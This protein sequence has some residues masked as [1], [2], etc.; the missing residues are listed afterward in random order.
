M[1]GAWLVSYIALWLLTAVLAIVV[2]AHS[3]LLGLLHYRLGP[4]GARPLAD[5]PELGSTVTR[6]QGRTL[7]GA[8]WSYTFP[9]PREVL[10]IFVSP[11]CQTCNS[12]LPHI[13]DFV[14]VHP[15]VDLLLIS[16]LD[17]PAMNRAYV[18][19]SRLPQERLTYVLGAR[20]AADLNIE[21]TPYA[22]YLDDAGVVRNKGVV[23]NYEHLFGLRQPPRIPSGA[24][25]EGEGRSEPSRNGARYES[26]KSEGRLD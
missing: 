10:A 21:G 11:Q 6:L 16:T 26:A 2:L 3:R 4:T 14:R 15:D 18:A 13:A 20:Q 1:E 7:D 24:D 9:A 12:L 5:G 17:D 8:P 25:G 22:V 19:F 23:N